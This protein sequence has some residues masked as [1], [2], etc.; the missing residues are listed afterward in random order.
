MDQQAR[1]E[2]LE[3]RVH[4][5]TVGAALGVSVAIGVVLAG[6]G[7]IASH[8]AGGA[9]AEFPIGVSA[10]AGGFVVVPTRQ[11]RY[12]RVTESSRLEHI[13]WR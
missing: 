4:R 7:G 6:A 3:R 1:I 13:R 10:P 8:G 9:G 5:L 11:G 12:E 2:A